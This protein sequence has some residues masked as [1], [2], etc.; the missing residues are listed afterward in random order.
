MGDGLSESRKMKHILEHRFFNDGAQLEVLI[1]DDEK[2]KVFRI[3][4][5]AKEVE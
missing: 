5:K 4:L 1:F 2:N 3:T